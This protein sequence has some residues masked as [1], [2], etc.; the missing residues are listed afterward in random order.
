MVL[1]VA[2]GIGAALSMDFE[3]K[4][5]VRNGRV[6]RIEPRWKVFENEDNS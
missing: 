6:Y 4:Y 3:Q 1:A 5:E 2:L